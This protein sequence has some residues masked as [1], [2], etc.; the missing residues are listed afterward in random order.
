MSEPPA[1]W[2]GHV[3]MQTSPGARTATSG[4]GAKLSPIARITSRTS[5]GASPTLAIPV[6]G[7]NPRLSD[8]ALL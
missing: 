5:R 8:L 6:P 3:S 1:I 7:V 4:F 2:P